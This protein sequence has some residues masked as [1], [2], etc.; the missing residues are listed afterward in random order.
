MARHK[1]RATRAGEEADGWREIASELRC[2]G[3]KD[4]A[5][6][7]TGKLSHDE[8]DSLRDEMESW[9]DGIPENLRG[10]DKYSQVDEACNALDSIDLSAA[11]DADW[12][13]DWKELAE[14]VADCLEN[15]ADELEGVEFPG[16]F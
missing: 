9:R 1:N 11:E 2:A 5:E 8:L 16:M 4:E 7:A 12:G 10:G 15:A 6:D 13:E 3:S 14:E